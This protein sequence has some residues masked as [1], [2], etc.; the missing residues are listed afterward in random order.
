MDAT[1]FLIQCLPRVPA[2][3]SVRRCRCAHS[4]LLLCLLLSWNPFAFSEEIEES[5]QKLVFEYSCEQSASTDY[6]IK[7]SDSRAGDQAFIAEYHNDSI[8]AEDANRSSLSDT[9][10]ELTLTG[11]TAGSTGRLSTVLGSITPTLQISVH[12]RDANKT[13]Q[14]TLINTFSISDLQDQQQVSFIDKNETGSHRWVIR[15]IGSPPMELRDWPTSATLTPGQLISS[16]VQLSK[17]ARLSRESKLEVEIYNIGKNQL[18]HN[19][20]YS[21]NS[22]N[23]SIIHFDFVAPS[24]NGVYEARLALT[25]QSNHLWNKL[26]GKPETIFELHRTFAVTGSVNQGTPSPSQWKG[27][28]QIQPSQQSWF[29]PDWLMNPTAHLPIILPSDEEVSTQFDVSKYEGE[30]VTQ[31]APLSQ[32]EIALGSQKGGVQL[33]TMRLPSNNHSTFEVEITNAREESLR[34]FT[35]PPNPNAT[36]EDPWQSI[37]WIHH[38]RSAERLRIKNLSQN[39]TLAFES[40]TIETN[41]GNLRFEHNQDGA[42][43]RTVLNLNSY[44]WV[45]ELSTDYVDQLQQQDWEQQSIEMYR[46]QLA[47]SR[48]IKQ[49][50]D[51]GFDTISIALNQDPPTALLRDN[52]SRLTSSI[53]NYQ[54]QL[55]VILSALDQS[56]LGVVLEF[57]PAISFLSNAS[58]PVSKL[59][60]QGGLSEIDNG[61]SP[62]TNFTDDQSSPPALDD[63]YDDATTKRMSETFQAIVD[64]AQSH[65]SVVALSL[66]ASGAENPMCRPI[67]SKNL[68]KL[69]RIFTEENPTKGEKGQDLKSTDL[70]FDTWLAQKR[71]GLWSNLFKPPVGMKLFI[72][73]TDAWRG[74]P[75]DSTL[76]FIETYEYATTSSL[77]TRLQLKRDLQAK[78][79]VQAIRLGIDQ[80]R[81]SQ[82]ES[83]AVLTADIVEVIDNKNPRWI[84]VDHELTTGFFDA[85]LIQNLCVF[86]HL[87]N[88]DLAECE[89]VAPGSAAVRVWSYFEDDRLHVLLINLVPW[90]TDVD[91]E[92]IEP[93][94]W[95]PV[96]KE[97]IEQTRHSISVLRPTR[98]RVSVP[99][100]SCVLLRS[101]NTG[102][103]GIRQWTS[104]VSGGPTV[105][106]RIKTQVTEVVENIGSLTTPAPNTKLLKN[107]SFEV[108]GEMGIIGWMHAQHPPGCV[109]LDSDVARNGS[110][111]ARLKTEINHTGRTWIMSDAFAPP[112]SGRVAVAL[113]LRGS[114]ITRT[115]TDQQVRVALETSGGDKPLRVFED[116][117][118]PTNKEWSPH[119][120]V[121]ELDPFKPQELGSLRVAIDSLKPGLI[122]VDDVQIYDD[123]PTEAERAEMQRRVFLAVQG[124]QR[125]NLLPAGKLLENFWVQRL[126]TDKKPNRDKNEPAVKR[127]DM[128]PPSVTERFKEWLPGNGRY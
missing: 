84:F 116:L 115:D 121:L 57:N 81:Q 2:N 64:L 102:L 62:G 45:A 25:G 65:Q 48:V 82:M 75:N 85:S 9:R 69:R 123:F 41:E 93:L 44:S 104:R 63:F 83:T 127:E 43:R 40:I 100:N 95:T 13:D 106:K 124:M 76:T 94:S 33:H 4:I 71:H 51:N 30:S 92:T 96:R 118:I 19:E 22:E 47:I 7:L 60:S 37:Q 87:P 54:T 46:L 86:S 80:T 1:S 110:N 35:V 109:L 12:R 18:V 53:W 89:A 125:G 38:P 90:A 42:T 61:N 108:S 26:T 70:D 68:Q 114:P 101:I 17:N 111:S 23:T 20:V 122:W 67:P 77:S 27:T 58:T 66:M 120:I 79:N 119:E 8:R 16:T 56:N 88:R 36:I 99:A 39:Q 72:S 5:H 32:F 50:I 128:E 14:W 15:R 113:T 31:L 97:L 107:G 103:N 74:A 21:V 28:Q 34:R 11:I 112:T 117:E 59:H 10:N 6:L 24:D 73:G 78:S 105:V 29:M 91:L 49:A 98:S 3:H 52:Q 126:L 55:E